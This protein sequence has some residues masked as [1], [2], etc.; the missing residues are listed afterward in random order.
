MS[1][2]YLVAK[3][4]ND[5]KS[6]LSMVLTD[7][8]YI[9]D[10]RIYERLLFAISSLD[11]RRSKKYK[12]QRNNNTISTTFYKLAIASVNDQLAGFLFVEGKTLWV[13]VVPKYRHQSIARNLWENLVNQYPVLDMCNVFTTPE[14][15]R[16]KDDSAVWFFKSIGVHVSMSIK[17]IEQE[18]LEF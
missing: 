8:R 12:F 5:L 15:D 18:C 3:S 7:F 10:Y 6:Y 17:N 1:N 14:L 4:A 9:L 13:Y 2:L 16:E 11:I